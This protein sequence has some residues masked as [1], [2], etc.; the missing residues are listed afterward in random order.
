MRFAFIAAHAG[1]WP[2]AVQCRVLEVSP[3][4]YYAWCRR[5][6]STQTQT[7]LALLERIR[8]IHDHSR[9]TYGSPRIHD[10]LLLSGVCCSVGR[11][12]RSMRQAGIRGT[13]PRRFV[14]TTQSGG[15]YCPAPNLLNR[16][17][18][19]GEVEALVADITALPTAE[20]Y[21]YLAV[22]LNLSTRQ[23]WGW[24]MSGRLHGGL[25]LDALE[26]AL[27][28]YTPTPGMLHH[29]DRGGQYVSH[30]FAALLAQHGLVA[31]MSRA[32]NCWDNA[33]VESF[34]ATLKRELSQPRLIRSQHE[35]RSIVFE[36]FEVFYNRQRMHSSLGNLTPEAYAKLHPVA[37]P[38]VH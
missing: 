23:V 26:M 8:E 2:V 33:V 29:S 21:L 20:G 6:P 22:V 35:A 38:I 28:R 3:S 37:I 11:V 13:R 32:A 18:K 7:G 16:R 14:V 10:A 15:A 5:G 1:R 17:F 36:Y 4:G 12:E 30:A 34:F 24:S 19:P 31:S 25:G 27:K 9:R